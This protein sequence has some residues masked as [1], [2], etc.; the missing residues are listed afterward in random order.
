M[1]KTQFDGASDCLTCDRANVSNAVH[2]ITQL[3][4][5]NESGVDNIDEAVELVRKEAEDLF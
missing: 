3:I 5:C 2:G 1:S 4:A